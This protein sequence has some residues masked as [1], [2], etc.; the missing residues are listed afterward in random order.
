MTTSPDLNSEEEDKL[1]ANDE[2][3]NR[4]SDS[5]L[6]KDSNDDICI[7]NQGTIP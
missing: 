7:Y 3:K 2:G 5:A 6:D 4:D 1:A